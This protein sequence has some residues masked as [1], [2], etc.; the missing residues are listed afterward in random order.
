MFQYLQESGME[1]NLLKSCLEL[2]SP[3]SIKGAI[4]AGMGVSILS[5]VSIAKELK[6]GSLLAIPL[7]QMITDQQNQPLYQ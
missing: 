4:E 3:E 5:S 1:R 7:N 6:L 2:G